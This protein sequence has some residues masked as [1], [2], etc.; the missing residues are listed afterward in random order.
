MDRPPDISILVCTYNRA[1][2]LRR[3]LTKLGELTIPDG[4][5]WDILVVDNGSKDDTKAVVAG[6]EG[7]LPIRYA[8]EPRPGKSYAL[9]TGLS[10]CTAPMIMMTDDDVDVEPTWMVELHRAALAHPEADFFGGKI[11]P[12]WE[13]PP[14]EWMARHSG[15]M[16]VGLTVNFTLGDEEA[17]LNSGGNT[18]LGANSAYRKKTLDEMGGYREDLGPHG[19]V[20]GFHEESE[21]IAR[22]LAAGYTGLYLPQML[23]H[24]RNPP[25]RTTQRYLLRW[26]VGCGKSDVLTGVIHPAPPNLLGA[27]R[28]LWR[29]LIL[30]AFHYSAGLITRQT[31]RE[32]LK[33]TFSMAK[34]WG[35]IQQFRKMNR[36]GSPQPG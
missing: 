23:V 17:I 24:H 12:R 14:P 11:V 18:F 15:D 3:T 26:L 27:P 7:R 4:I 5:R 36:K 9:N 31:D 10:L 13:E 21:Y 19:A 8:L 20:M 28:Y 32:W 6:F 1:G 30:G 29:Q 22:L 34:A 2:E 16:L 25:Q 33:A 35:A